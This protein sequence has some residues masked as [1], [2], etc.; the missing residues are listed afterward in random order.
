MSLLVGA[1]LGFALGYLWKRT[2]SEHY[3]STACHHGLH[4]RCRKVCKHCPEACGCP[5][6]VITPIPEEA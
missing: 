3:V 2:F 4:E 1:V 5:C 6:H